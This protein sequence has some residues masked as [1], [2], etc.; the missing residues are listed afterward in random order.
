MPTGAC[1]DPG[2]FVRPADPSLLKAAM[3]NTAPVAPI[4]SAHQD[5]VATAHNT[6][7]FGL[8]LAAAVIAGLVDR[9]KGLGPFTVFAPNDDAFRKLSKESLA[10]LHLPE[11]RAKLVAL[12]TLH[13]V[14]SKIM[15]N[16]LAGKV[17][18]VNSLQ[19]SELI[20]DATTG[21]TVNGVKVLEADIEASNGAIHVIDTLL[22]PPAV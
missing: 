4:L 21:M 14:A 18:R 5:L 19:G 1:V 15:S 2:N 17:T 22:T 10:G 9:L 7:D 6:G 8:L 20:V 3:S 11:G 16:A 13:R 12:L